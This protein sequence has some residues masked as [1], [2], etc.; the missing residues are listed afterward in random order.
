MISAFGVDHG[1]D[2]SKGLRS[3]IGRRLDE[4]AVRIASQIAP[5]GTRIGNRNQAHF[6]EARVMDDPEKAESKFTR[7]RRLGSREVQ[8]PLEHHRTGEMIGHVQARVYPT[9]HSYIAGLLVREGN[10]G[11]GIGKTSLKTLTENAKKSDAPSVR[12]WA[13]GTGGYNAEAGTNLNGNRAWRGGDARFNRG[14]PV[15]PPNYRAARKALKAA[16]NK[17]DLR[18][19]DHTVARAA[20]G[21]V[22]PR[23]IGHTLTPGAQKA[24]DDN[25]VIWMGA[26]NGGKP[27]MRRTKYAVGGG[28]TALGGAEVM[29]RREHKR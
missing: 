16:G 7:I 8:I 24:W 23:D 3:F 14:M 13:N 5:E 11:K 27:F 26:V 20:V 4:R 19:L 17:E 9:G 6:A 22:R 29:R 12:F 28:A 25:N 21:A 10:R 2:V 1:T 18:S 15:F